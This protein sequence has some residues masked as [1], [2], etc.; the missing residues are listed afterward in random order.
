MAN[1]AIA[2]ASPFIFCRLGQKPVGAHDVFSVSLCSRG[3][4]GSLIFP[5]FTA[6]YGICPV[7]ILSPYSIYTLS[8]NITQRTREL[9]SSPSLFLWEHYS[10]KELPLHWNGANS[11][12][13]AHT[14][15]PRRKLLAFLWG[16]PGGWAGS[17]QL[18]REGLCQ[19]RL[20]ILCRN[21]SKRQLCILKDD[22][23]IKWQRLNF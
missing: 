20:W 18:I 21:H 9:S 17:K 7:N 15:H 10:R 1:R 3:V 16:V 11:P 22:Q 2:D 5:V 23:K 6:A 8:V 14:A 12:S 4:W 13:E 19:W